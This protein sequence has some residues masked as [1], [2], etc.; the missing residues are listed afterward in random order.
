M[1]PVENT[2]KRWTASE[3]RKLPPDQRAAILEAAA[4]V[5]EQEYRDTPELTAFE[6]F[7]N[8]D[9]FGDSANGEKAIS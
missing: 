6:A 4:A 1:S 3:L 7:G 2:P 5:A 8:D 9:L